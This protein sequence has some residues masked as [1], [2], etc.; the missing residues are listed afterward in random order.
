MSIN[1]IP[2][3]QALQRQRCYQFYAAWVVSIAINITILT[4][5]TVNFRHANQHW[6]IQ[7]NILI[8][9]KLMTQRFD[10]KPSRSK[11]KIQRLLKNIYQIRYNTLPVITAIIQALLSHCYLTRIQCEIKV[12]TLTGVD[13]QAAPI[14]T[15]LQR[16]EETKI[17]Q[18]VSLT[19]IRQ[20]RHVFF[21]IQLSDTN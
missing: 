9:R 19:H 13:R 21:T 4:L 5:L 3:R 16:L 12:W 6:R 2:W 8:N 1:L 14:F 11:P 20:Q 17:F 7:N 18:H 10:S 15:F